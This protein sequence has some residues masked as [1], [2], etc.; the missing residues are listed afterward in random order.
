MHILRE[1]WTKEIEEADVKSSY[2]YI[3][4][5]REGLDDTLKITREELE[6]AQ[7]WQKHYYD[8]TAKR[9]KFSVGEKEIALIQSHQFHMKESEIKGLLSRLEEEDVKIERALAREK[10]KRIAIE[11]LHTE[12]NTRDEKMKTLKSIIESHAQLNKSLSDKAEELSSQLRQLQTQTEM[13]RCQRDLFGTKLLQSQ[14]E[15]QLCQEKLRAANDSFKIHSVDF[16]NMK[17]DIRVLIL[18]IKNLRRKIK[19]SE[20]NLELIHTLR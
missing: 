18:E 4:N 20:G 7:G 12:I 14:A 19:L 16:F 13:I 17:N 6:K 5:L 15:T 11:Q 3:L 2:E 1:L 9:R 10:E 8:R